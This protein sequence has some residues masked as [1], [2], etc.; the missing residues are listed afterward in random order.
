[1]GQ[2]SL[3]TKNRMISQLILTSLMAYSA[4]ASSFNSNPNVKHDFTTPEIIRKAGYQDETH[5]VF[6]EDRYIL[7]MHRIRGDGPVVLCQHGLEDSSATWLLAGPDHGA[8]AFRLA[9]AG[10]D[11]WLGNY[12]GNSY[13]RA[14][15]DLDPDKDNAYWQFSWDEMA[16][17]DLP[18][19]LTTVL[20]RTGK[21]KIYYIGHSMGTTTFMAMNSVNQSWAD[22]IELAVLLAP[23]A[24]VENM[25]SPI[26]Y[27]APFSNSI[28]WIADHLGMGEF[29]PS[30]WLMDLLA[31]LACTDNSLLQGV[32]ENVVFLLTGYDQTQ[33]NETML[34]TI[35]HHIPAG[36]S[37]YTILQYAQGVKSK[38]F[39]GFDWGDDDSNMAHHDS[40]LPPMYDLSKINTK[41]ALFWGD[42][43]WLAQAGDL[44]K[45]IMKVPTIVE[46]Y[47]VPWPEWNH[48]D[49]LYAIDIDLYQ[50]IHLLDILK[51]YPIQ[52]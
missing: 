9:E 28:Q 29:L 11:V 48:L 3:Q 41:I 2:L 42:N 39:M 15:R 31:S 43:D 6:T 47:E 10:Y 44:I 8:P 23:V 7:T 35:A 22:H 14:H 49:F 17:Y 40:V 50:N 32:C 37:S 18:A 25:A 46:N 12:R 20:E 36:T 5:T 45:I 21:E 52:E 34:D 26:A 16:K 30:N 38:E 33:M 1:M 19:Q 24:Y 27:L 51:K 4:L 13:S